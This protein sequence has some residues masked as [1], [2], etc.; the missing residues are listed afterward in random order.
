MWDIVENLVQPPTN[1]A[2][3]VDFNKKNG[4][5]RRIIHDAIKDH[6]FP[7]VTGMTFSCEMWDSIVTLL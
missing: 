2:Q 6:L 4:K 7:H 1:P 3:L 5:A